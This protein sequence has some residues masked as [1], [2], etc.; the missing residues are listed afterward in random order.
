MAY[1]DQNSGVKVGNVEDQVRIRAPVE[2]SYRDKGYISLM[3][4]IKII[5]PLSFESIHQFHFDIFTM[6]LRLNV[7]QTVIILLLVLICFW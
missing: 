4:L 7:T 5:L 1:L 2:N 3:L 6:L